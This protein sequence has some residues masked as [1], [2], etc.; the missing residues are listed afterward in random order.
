MRR[1]G[2]RAQPQAP[3][4]PGQALDHPRC[5]RCGDADLK[6]FFVEWFSTLS[7]WFLYEFCVQGDA[8]RSKSGGMIPPHPPGFRPHAKAREAERGA[9]PPR[10]TEPRSG[11]GGRMSPSPTLL[12]NLERYL[13][14]QVAWSRHPAKAGAGGI[15]WVIRN[16]VHPVVAWSPTAPLDA[17]A[18]LRFVS[19]A[20][21]ETFCRDPWPVGRPCHNS[22]WRDRATTRAPCSRPHAQSNSFPAHLTRPST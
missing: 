15:G 7:T 19:T 5:W 10:Q 6:C 2:K 12:K 11:E 18:G 13:V 16:T 22:G 8:L 1:P 20:L 14:L 9:P 21:Q 4:G 17:T 3:P